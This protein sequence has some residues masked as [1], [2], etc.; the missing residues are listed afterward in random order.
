MSLHD[1]SDSSTHNEEMNELNTNLSFS[2]NDNAYN[3]S[4]CSSS[5]NSTSDSEDDNSE[6]ESLND[7]NRT[8]LNN[9]IT[10]A[11]INESETACNLIH[12]LMKENELIAL[13]QNVPKWGGSRPGRSANK[14]RDFDFAYTKLKKDYFSGHQSTYDERN[15]ETRFRVSRRVFNTVYNKLYGLDP[16]IHKVDALGKKGIHPL[17]RLTSCFRLIAYGDSCDREDENMRLSRSSMNDALKSFCNLIIEQFG[18]NYLNRTPNEK[19]RKSILKINEKRGFPGL[20]AS[21]DCSHFQW[22]KCPIQLHGQF[23]NGRYKGKTIVLEAVVD[24][25]LR[26]WYAHFGFPG[27]LND[28]NVLDK[29]NIVGD[30]LDGSFSLKTDN[31]IINGV[32]R[33]YVYFL[34]DGAY[35]DWAIFVSTCK[36]PINEKEKIFSKQQEAVRKDVER[37]FAVISSKFQILSRPFRLWDLSDIN[38]V[39]QCCVIIHNMQVEERISNVGEEEHYN[40]ILYSNERNQTTTSNNDDD[41]NF[42]IFNNESVIIYND[43]YTNNIRDYV[44][45]RVSYMNSMIHDKTKHYNLMKD[46]IEHIYKNKDN[47]YKY[48]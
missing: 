26:V 9:F 6:D 4:S 44:S 30:I 43:Q 22:D 34:V 17:V 35:P 42:N 24:C 27:T 1:E 18:D 10:K 8:N 23:K 39:M 46:L 3:S 40:E 25:N 29:S 5:N 2:S 21:W 36:H 12:S 38:K 20:L 33:D 7:T 47:I 11:C 37:V 13:Q 48:Y 31:Y 14:D 32:I 15:F 16:F 41:N 45:K 19:E 28:I